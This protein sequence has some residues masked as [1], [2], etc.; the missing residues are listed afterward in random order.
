MPLRHLISPPGVSPRSLGTL[1]ESTPALPPDE[2]SPGGIPR[3]MQGVA[4]Q[5][6]GFDPLTT[7]EAILCEA[8]WVTDKTARTLKDNVLFDAFAFYDG[9]EGSILCA[10]VPRF[11]G[12]IEI[13]MPAMVSEQFALELMIGAKRT[14]A[15]NSTE[16]TGFG[17]VNPNFVDDATVIPGGP[18]PPLEALAL[19][20]QASADTHHGAQSYLHV[21]PKGMSFLNGFEHGEP[22]NNRWTTAQGHVV[23]GD[24]GYT[25][26]EPTA[27][28]GAVAADEWWYV[29]GPVFWAMSQPIPLG[30]PFERIDF[31]T[32]QL[33]NILEGYG[34]VVFD[35]NGVVAVPVEYPTPVP[36]S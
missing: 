20:E 27:N 26:P 11:D 33:T 23:I 5:P 28:G 4:F 31:A 7:I 35:P 12:D 29:S 24:A 13:R 22:I 17:T 3:W 16:G 36:A 15:I 19:L 25:G 32:N 2:I 10:D 9:I 8:D 30:L 6:L 18:Y 34:L 21:T 1:L 14:R